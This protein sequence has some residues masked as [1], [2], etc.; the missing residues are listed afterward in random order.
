[1]SLYDY[2]VQAAKEI[3]NSDDTV[4]NKQHLFNVLTARIPAFDGI[5]ADSMRASTFANESYKLDVDTNALSSAYSDLQTKVVSDKDYMQRAIRNAYASTSVIVTYYAALKSFSNMTPY[6]TNVFVPTVRNVQSNDGVEMIG[7]V[8]LNSPDVLSTI[9]NISFSADCDLRTDGS[10]AYL[11][12]YSYNSISTTQTASL[13]ISFPKNKVSFVS[14]ENFTLGAHPV[15]VLVDGNQLADTDYDVYYAGA[16]IRIYL[17]QPYDA[18]SVTVV[19]ASYIQ[20][21]M[22]DDELYK[23]QVAQKSI[24]DFSLDDMY[25]MASNIYALTGVKHLQNY[26]KS[27]GA[28]TLQTLSSFTFMDISNIVVGYAEFNSNSLLSYTFDKDIYGARIFPEYPGILINNTYSSRTF[29]E[30]IHADTLDVNVSPKSKYVPGMV[31]Y[32]FA[33]YR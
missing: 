25:R 19:F 1:M 21:H 32:I 9:N 29:A 31:G 27:I 10:N 14:F 28:N 6:Y 3:A 16:T 26:L 2:Y 11:Y 33:L 22:R 18:N 24:S 20:E 8:L 12:K 4:V 17:H 7:T 23:L 30:Q 15:A 13:T 5:R